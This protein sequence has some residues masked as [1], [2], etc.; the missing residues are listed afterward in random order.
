M[1]WHHFGKAKKVFSTIKFSLSI[2]CLYFSCIPFSKPISTLNVASSWHICRLIDLEK[3]P[4]IYTRKRK[5]SNKTDK[6]CK[7]SA[8][9]SI[10][11]KIFDMNLVQWKISG[12]RLCIVAES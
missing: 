4:Q 10:I 2:K 12:D 8:F 7:K 11:K 6:K 1:L 5:K 9:F 3:I